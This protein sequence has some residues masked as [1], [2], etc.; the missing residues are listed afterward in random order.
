MNVAPIARES[1]SLALDTE[2]YASDSARKLRVL[3]VDDHPI[4]RQGMKA[5][6][7]QQ[8]NL[9]VCGEAESAA[10]ALRLVEALSPDLAVVDIS[11][12]HDNG[13]ELTHELKS[14]VP[15]VVVLVV[16]M[17]EETTYAERAL[18]A[19]AGGYLM[20]QEAGERF[21]TALQQVLRGDV[22]LSPRMQERLG[23][24]VLPKRKAHIFPFDTLSERERQVFELI[25][26]GFSTR[27]IAEKLNISSKT[28]DSYRDHLKLKLGLDSGA[29]L[30]RHAIAWGRTKGP[31]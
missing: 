23:R 19:G 13:I 25:G 14:R 22:F 16:S 28:V 20:K 15:G 3:L 7:E 21:T 18:R 8:R 2:P 27:Q 30:V 9:E 24:R 31:I 10:D 11:L 12:R 1:S 6:I 29:E 26:D 5:L 17:L 4:T